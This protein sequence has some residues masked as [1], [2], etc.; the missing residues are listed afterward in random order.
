MIN[1]RMW[2]WMKWWEKIL[3]VDETRIK[4]IFQRKDS[5][6]TAKF[7]SHRINAGTLFVDHSLSA[8]NFYLN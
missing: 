6:A 5:L 4:L 2:V 3:L 7:C 8:L 1:K